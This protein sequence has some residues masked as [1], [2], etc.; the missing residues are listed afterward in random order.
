MNH[1]IIM[2]GGTGTRFW[3]LSR[4]ALP[5]Q[6]LTLFGESSLLRQ[7]YER[8]QAMFPPERV[9]V[10]TNA[11]YVH[12]V[13][14]QIPELPDGNVIGEPMARNTAPCIAMAAEVLLARDPD[15]VMAVLP[16]DHSIRRV[17]QFMEVLQLCMDEAKDSEGLYTI[18]ITPNRPE[19]GYG[20][21]QYDPSSKRATAKVKTFAEKPDFETAQAFLAS[22]DFLWNSGMF[23]WRADR[24]KEEFRRHLPEMAKLADLFAADIRTDS[25][26]GAVKRF[27]EVS[28]SI[29]IDYGIM[30]KAAGVRVVPADIGWSDVGSWMAAWELADKDPYGNSVIGQPVELVNAHNCYVRGQGDRLIALVGMEDTVVVD[31]GDAILIMPAHKSQDI[32]K[33]VDRLE[34]RG[35][36]KYR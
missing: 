35:D 7:T 17:D 26:Q 14:A 33:L 18:G 20:Y 3:P 23:V 5:K 28:P 27:Y 16:A 1:A 8:I 19:T 21:I 29:S 34:Q 22:G 24:I 25:L 32:R 2:A 10:V 12:L 11:A 4:K 31:T 6:F 30:E 9:I 13:K 36:H 15:A